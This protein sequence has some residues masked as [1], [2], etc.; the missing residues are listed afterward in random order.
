MSAGLCDA[1]PR[2]AVERN[3]VMQVGRAF[4]RRGPLSRR[5]QH[6]LIR[7]VALPERPASC[8]ANEQCAGCEGALPSGTDHWRHYYI[9]D[10]LLHSVAGL[11]SHARVHDFSLVRH[12]GF[13]DDLI[14]GVERN[15]AVLDQQP[16]QGRH[17]ARVHLAG[18][19]R[20]G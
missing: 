18:M 19:I 4:L 14:R 5:W 12:D 6:A 16:Q 17:V 1:A 11:R 15:G 8:C 10:D 3:K 2:D 7:R 20:D 9:A 13:A